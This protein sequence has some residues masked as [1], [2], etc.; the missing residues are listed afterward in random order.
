MWLDLS[1]VR[2]NTRK[3]LLN[4]EDGSASS[5]SSV[6]GSP[7]ATSPLSHDSP[8][9]SPSAPPILSPPIDLEGALD[10]QSD[11]QLSW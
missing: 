1:E 4:Y 5:S 10:V 2:H 8:L 6:G 7:A 9:S 3:H 11:A